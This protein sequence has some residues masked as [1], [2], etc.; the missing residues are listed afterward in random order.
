MMMRREVYERIGGMDAERF[1][2]AYNDVEICVRALRFGYRN[3]YTPHA[4]LKHHQ[5][6]SRKPVDHAG[7]IKNLFET[8]IGPAPWSDPY[9]HPLLNLHRVDFSLNRDMLRER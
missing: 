6:A 8:C 3:V 7:E 4:V 9:Y 1:A 2:V 5:S